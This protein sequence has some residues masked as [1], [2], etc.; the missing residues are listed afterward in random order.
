VFGDILPGPVDQPHVTILV[1][2]ECAWVQLPDVEL[3]SWHGTFIKGTDTC[4][5]CRAK[6]IAL[7]LINRGVFN[8]KEG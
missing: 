3:L 6:C 1:C 8:G 4:P 2:L 7:W 5:N